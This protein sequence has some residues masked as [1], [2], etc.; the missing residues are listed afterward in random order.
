[1]LNGI[2]R[3][4]VAFGDAMKDD[5]FKEKVGKYSSKEIGRTA[6]ERKAGSLGYAESMLSRLILFSFLVS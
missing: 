3:L 4:I 6:K 2:A 5:A 1:M